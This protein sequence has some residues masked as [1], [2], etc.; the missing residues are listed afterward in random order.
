MRRIGELPSRRDE[1]PWSVRRAAWEW[2]RARPAILTGIGLLL[3]FGLAPWPFAQKAQALLHGLCA[4]RLSHSFLLGGQALPFDA[5]M[6][7]IYGAFL[8]TMMYL[9]GTGRARA[10]GMPSRPVLAA[11]AAFVLALAVDGTNSTLRDFGLWHAYLPDNRLRLA[12]GLL[13]G[14]ALAAL[15]CHLV[16]ITLWKQGDWRTSTVRGLPEVGLL[17]A[18]Q[19]PFGLAVVS[20]LGVL[21]APVAV[22]LVLSALGVFLVMAVV[23]LAI[24]RRRDQSYRSIAELQPVLAVGL[25]A[26]V[27]TISALAGGRYLL[28]WWLG[29]PPM[30]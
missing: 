18:I 24:V 16:A 5:R 17:V 14:I 6:T 12:T 29:I 26:A 25:M 8:V 22:L 27:L 19:V 28:E 11:L 10:W 21:Y 20:G 9:L 15:L 2:L 30:I 7:G 1:S 23:M 4:Q 13:T 3:A